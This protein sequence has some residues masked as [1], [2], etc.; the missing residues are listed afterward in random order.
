MFN[1]YP[2]GIR[3]L[4][5]M[6]M[7]LVMSP[8]ISWA[9]ACGC[10]V[11]GV[12]TRSMFPT[13][14]GGWAWVEYDSMNQAQNFHGT[15]T[16][17]EEDSDNQIIR[18]QFMMAGFQYMANRE[19]GIMMELPYWSRY[20]QSVDNAGYNYSSIGDMRIKGVYTGL[21][22]DMSTGITFGLKLPTGPFQDLNLDRDTQIGTGSTDVLLGIYH[23][24]HLT[25]DAAWSWFGNI[26]LDQPVL[27][28][29]GYNPGAEVDGVLGV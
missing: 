13:D 27:T 8:T 22:S 2:L 1:Q 6:C 16:A 9:C 3:F 20:L 18:T 11:F 29:G 23:M 14:K 15:S 28:Q 17:P 21:S 19:W 25:N 4:A 24:G 7:V 5:V 10:D 26:Q 12:G